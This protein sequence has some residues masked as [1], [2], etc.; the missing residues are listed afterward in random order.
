[1]LLEDNALEMTAETCPASGAT[2]PEVPLP[3]VHVPVVP[4]SWEDLAPLSRCGAPPAA[5][6]ASNPDGAEVSARV[7]EAFALLGRQ[8]REA[9]GTIGGRFRLA[10]QHFF[11]DA[12]F[13]IT[14]ADAWGQRIV[15]LAGGFSPS[16]PRGKIP[17]ATTGEQTVEELVRRIKKK[18]KTGPGRADWLEHCSTAGFSTLDP[19]RHHRRFLV[20]FLDA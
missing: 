8:R 14:D 20:A 11:N 16:P 17:M 4:A 13:V 1:M 19:S 5:R 12:R 7:D 3:A 2:T 9:L 10:K 15:S 18:C 6:D